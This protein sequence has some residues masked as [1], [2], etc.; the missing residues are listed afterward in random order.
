M[1]L[2]KLFVGQQWR[3]RQRIDLWTWESWEEGEGGIYRESN[4]ENYIAIYK[5]ANGNVLYDS[6][7]SNLGSITT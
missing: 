4:M 2:I 3:H 5:I 1:V 6:G 7:N